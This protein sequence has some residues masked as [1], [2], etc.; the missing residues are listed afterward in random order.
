MKE[1]DYYADLGLARGASK[2]AIKKAYRKLARELHPDRNPDNPKAE[3]RFK[4][5]S[6]AYRVLSDE[7]KRALYDEFGM[8]GLREG[9]DP[10]MA[11]ARAAGF[12][13][14]PGGTPVGGFAGGMPFDASSIFEQMR[15]AAAPRTRDSVA[16]LRL[17][18]LTALK[19]GVQEIGLR[20]EDGSG[21]T[22]K[23][24]IP[25]GVRD[26]DELRLAKQGARTRR[27]RSDL[28]LQLEV[29]PHPMA[30][31]EGEAMHLRVPVRPGEA[32]AGG[33]IELSTPQGDVQ[34]KIPEA[35]ANGTKLR[36]R[37]KG[38]QRKGKGPP[39]DLIVHLELVLP[40]LGRPEVR[41]AFEVLDRAVEGDPRAQLPRFT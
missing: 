3:E 6:E 29:T 8:V 31:F 39:G 20:E 37:G 1:P 2:E 22:I 11:R 32:I 18:F 15:G 17:D 36:L 23:V 19:G 35:M 24:R 38:P 25:S 13:G 41:K 12:G 33:R 28:V 9:F 26:G 27:G 5:V 10:E 14:F 34:L 40:D 4:R 7:K 21:R 16:T 30:W